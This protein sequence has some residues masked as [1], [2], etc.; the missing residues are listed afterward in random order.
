MFDYGEALVEHKIDEEDVVAVQQG[1]NPS[2][3][4]EACCGDLMQQHME[5]KENGDDHT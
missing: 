5:G 4:K 2:D 1:K 3:Q